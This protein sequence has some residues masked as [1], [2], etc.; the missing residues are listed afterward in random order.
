LDAIL[1]VHCG[2]RD[3][4]ARVKTALTNYRAGESLPA[5]VHVELSGIPGRFGGRPTDDTLFGAWVDTKSGFSPWAALSSFPATTQ[6]EIWVPVPGEDFDSIAPASVKIM[7]IGTFASGGENGESVLPDSLYEGYGFI[8]ANL[9]TAASLMYFSG[10][11]RVYAD[12]DLCDS[13]HFQADMR[14]PSAGFYFIY[15]KTQGKDFSYEL[16]PSLTGLSYAIMTFSD[17]FDAHL[18]RM[19]D[20]RFGCRDGA[21]KRAPGS[22]RNKAGR[23]FPFRH[24]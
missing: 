12:V 21:F 10:P 24:L 14:V 16:L 6:P 5:Q 22:K 4:P 11:A 8:D 17:T 9:R 3:A 18:T 20:A 13:S 7:R 19:E 15:Q 2:T 1:T 23:Q